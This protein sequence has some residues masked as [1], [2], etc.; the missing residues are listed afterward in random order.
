MANC[1]GSLEAVDCHIRS[2]RYKAVAAAGFK[3][4]TNLVSFHLEI[5]LQL[6]KFNRLL[7]KAAVAF[8]GAGV[9]QLF[10]LG[11]KSSEG[12]WELLSYPPPLL[13]GSLSRFTRKRFDL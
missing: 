2:V 4:A 6:F 3:I 10:D 1:N 9:G 13:H 11:A 7:L 12:P 5:Q 8:A